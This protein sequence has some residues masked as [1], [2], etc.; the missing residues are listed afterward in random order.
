[1]E[2]GVVS[3]AILS[4]VSALRQLSSTFIQIFNYISTSCVLIETKSR[5]YK[6]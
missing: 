1:M 6:T 2:N 5:P 3:H 4:I